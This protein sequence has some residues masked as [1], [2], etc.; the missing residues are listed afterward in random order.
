VSYF[1][2]IVLTCYNIPILLIN[3]CVMI[4]ISHIKCGKVG[5]SVL[6]VGNNKLNVWGDR[7]N[8]FMSLLAAEGEAHIAGLLHLASSR[9]SREGQEN[10]G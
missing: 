9:I 5:T 1:C 10:C 7:F 6:T 2:S 4:H 8:A 3:T